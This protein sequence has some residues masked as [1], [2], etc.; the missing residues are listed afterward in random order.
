MLEE[1][2]V[3]EERR[4]M[5]EFKVSC[6]I[7]CLV[8]AADNRE[9][10]KFLFSSCFQQ[11]IQRAE[12]EKEALEKNRLAIESEERKLELEIERQR[13]KMKVFNDRH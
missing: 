2:K 13:K 12:A 8:V 4:K 3:E 5:V 1:E 11:T 9:A 10:I 6:F 7:P